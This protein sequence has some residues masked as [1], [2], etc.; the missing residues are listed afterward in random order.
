MIEIRFTNQRHLVLAID[1]AVYEQAR[2]LISE[3]EAELQTD[4][5]GGDIFLK[6]P[7]SAVKSRTK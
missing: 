5:V 2:I 1:G 3:S 6:S 7:S 4:S